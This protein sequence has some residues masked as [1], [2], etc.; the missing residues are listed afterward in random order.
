MIVLVD[1]KNYMIRLCDG[2]P[3]VHGFDVSFPNW[4]GLMKLFSDVGYTVVMCGK[5]VE[6]YL[7]AQGIYY[8]HVE[9]KAKENFENFKKRMNRMIQENKEYVLKNLSFGR[10]VWGVTENLTTNATMDTLN[11]VEVWRL[12]EDNK[13]HIGVSLADGMP[14]YALIATLEKIEKLAVE[15][16]NVDMDEVEELFYSHPTEEELLT[17]DT[18]EEMAINLVTLLSVIANK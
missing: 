18:M 10:F 14:R 3:E 17:A 1:N 7:D 13:Y 8:I 6:D 11:V 12:H 4:R 15:A 9:H 5:E 2:N 16:F